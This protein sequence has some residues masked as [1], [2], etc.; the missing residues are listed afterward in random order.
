M[1]KW[2]KEFHNKVFSLLKHI[3]VFW[4]SMHRISFFFFKFETIS[5]KLSWELWKLCL[6]FPLSAYT[7]L[8]T[9]NILW[10]K[11]CWLFLNTV[12]R[13]KLCAFGKISIR[14]SNNNQKTIEKLE[15]LK[16][17]TVD[18]FFNVYWERNFLWKSGLTIPIFLSMRK[19]CKI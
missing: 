7:M 1:L 17:L 19:T 16:A 2:E 10:G 18:P 3:R 15:M 5:D 4:N 8:L 9:H 14:W 6:K 12:K 13:V 11:F